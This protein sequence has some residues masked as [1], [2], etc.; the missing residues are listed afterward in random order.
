MNLLMVNGISA[1]V[2]EAQ[3]C[4]ARAE[5]V[6]QSGSTSCH[7]VLEYLGLT[8]AAQKLC[9]KVSQEYLIGVK[10]TCTDISPGMLGGFL[11]YAN[12]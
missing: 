11:C 5:Q 6:N 4:S 12:D 8:G 7:A 2:L 3:H 1:Q 9:R 10:C